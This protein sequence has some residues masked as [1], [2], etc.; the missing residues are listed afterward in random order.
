MSLTLLLMAALVLSRP[1][2]IALF[3]GNLSGWIALA[4]ALMLVRP[5]WAGVPVA[6]LG[7]LKMTPVVLLLPLLLR[8]DTRPT[9]ARSIAVV[10][11]VVLA[12]VALAPAAW[13]AWLDAL[14]N[15]L[16]FPA[17]EGLGNLAPSAVLGDVGLRPLG[18]AISGVMIVV[19]LVATIQG[20]VHDDWLKAVSGPVTVLL[21][22]STTV[23]D[24]YLA[25]SIVLCV[26]AWPS[27]DRV[28]RFW[29]AWLFVSSTAA[30]FPTPELRPVWFI[31]MVGASLA[32]CLR[33]RHRS[34]TKPLGLSDQAVAATTSDGRTARAPSS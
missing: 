18:V 6:V 2:Q 23:W 3:V 34:A 13:G 9:T 8:Q 20:V 7:V 26:A 21:F 32:L 33:P 29:T 12:M 30:W 14:P 19:G 25:A 22:A 4:V 28:A 27:A 17:G 10:G 15:I 24:H 11:A 1:V 16:R 5:R 31:A